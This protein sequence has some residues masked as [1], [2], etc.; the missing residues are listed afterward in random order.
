MAGSLRRPA[1]PSR[2][3]LR[4]E[5]VRPGRGRRVLPGSVRGRIVRRTK[6][7]GLWAGIFL[8]ASQRGWNA[9]RA[10]SPGIPV[11]S[12]LFGCLGVPVLVSVPGFLNSALRVQR[13]RAPRSRAPRD[14]VPGPLRVLTCLRTGRAGA[15]RNIDASMWAPAAPCTLAGGPVQRL[16]EPRSPGRSSLLAPRVA[17][18]GAAL[19]H[20]EPRSEGHRPSQILE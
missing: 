5:G 12:S 8:V 9:R 17:S 1:A 10:P 3:L 15:L 7:R 11:N 18:P 6:R 2:R 20:P 4:S 13:R 16:C 14:R 19:A